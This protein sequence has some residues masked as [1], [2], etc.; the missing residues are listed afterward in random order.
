ML[1]SDGGH[2]DRKNVRLDETGSI[3]HRI[4]RRKNL[5]DPHEEMYP[6]ERAQKES[7]VRNRSMR[8]RTISEH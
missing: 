3:H 5:T 1:C 8:A 6:V 2:H 4:D 7:F